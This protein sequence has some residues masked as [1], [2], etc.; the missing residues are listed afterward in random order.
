MMA[1]SL[2]PVPRRAARLDAWRRHLLV[3]CA[4]GATLAM[5]AHGDRAEAQAFNGS[6]FTQDGSVGYSRFSNPTPGSET[7]TI[8]SPSAIIQ[9]STTGPGPD[10]AVD[11]LPAGNIATFQNGE[12]V[13]NFVVLNRI[14]PDV[15][16]APVRFDGTVISRLFDIASGDLIGPGGTVIFQN[17][18]GIIVGANAVFDVGNLV[19]TS[20]GIDGD[21][22]G[23]G[24]GTFIN[25]G[26]GLD[27]AGADSPYDQAITIESGAQINALAEGSYVVLAAPRIEQGGAVR[28]NGNVA[29]VGGE[30]ATFTV[31]DGIFD[32]VLQAG[33]DGNETPIIHTGSTGGPASTG[34]GDQHNIYMLTAPYFFGQAT[35]MLLSGSIGY[36]DA[37]S[38]TFENGQIILSSGFAANLSGGKYAE[39]NIEITGGTLTSDVFATATRNVLAT[40]EDGALSFSGD[41]TAV[42][43]E[44]A[45]LGAVNGAVTVDGD[46]RLTALGPLD[47]EDGYGGQAGFAP[48][49]LDATGGTAEITAENGE[50]VTIVGNATLDA[51]A[52]GEFE[53]DGDLDAGEG[54]GGDVRVLATTG[55]SIA[56]GGDLEMTA[57]GEGAVTDYVP[58][59]GGAGRGGNATISA[60]NGGITVDGGLF[61]DVSGTGSRTTGSVTSQGA[62]GAG[63]FVGVSASNGSVEIAGAG[64]INASGTG[65]AV[66]LTDD[67][68]T[69]G[70]LG[71]GGFI[72]IDA[73]NGDVSLGSAMAI[74]ISG[75]GGAGPSGGQ[76]SGGSLFASA[77]GGEI[78]LGALG[79]DARG[80]GGASTEL[81]TGGAGFGGTV[82]A[83]AF[84]SP[85]SLITGTDTAINTDGIGGDGEVGGAGTAGGIS[86]VAEADEGSLQFGDIT[87]SSSGTGGAGAA[88]GG[89]G[90]GGDI[91]IGTEQGYGLGTSASVS[92]GGLDLAATGTGGDATGTTGGAGTGGSISLG[93]D[94]GQVTVTGAST[95]NVEGQ[96]GS[97][98]T[99]AGGT[100]TGG[101]SQ[102]FARGGATLSFTSL[103]MLS[104][105]RGG[106]GVTGGDGFGGQRVTPGG[107]LPGANIFAVDGTVTGDS[108]TLIVRGFG[109]DA[110]GAAGAGTGGEAQ[111]FS[112]NSAEP[113]SSVSIGTA[114]IEASGD[115]GASTGGAGGDALGGQVTVAAQTLNGAIAINSLNV[116]A[117]GQGGNGVTGGSAV[118]GLATV[119]TISGNETSGPVSGS[120]N[121]GLIVVTTSGRGG[122][123]TTGDG[124]D[125]TG[126]RSILLGRGST[127]QTGNVTLTSIGGGGA[128]ASGA[129]GDGAGGEAVIELSPRFQTGEP[130]D[131]SLGD[132]F[133]NAIGSAGTGAT[134]GAARRGLAQVRVLGGAADFASITMDVFGNDDPVNSALEGPTSIVVTDSQ[135]NVAG[136]VNVD[137]A[138]DADVSV[139][140]GSLAIGGNAVFSVAAAGTGNDFAMR[141]DN[142]TIAIDGA[143]Q[144]AAA[145]TGD[146]SAVDGV[147][148]TV[149]VQSL[150]GA[151]INIGGAT[152]ID[153]R[154]VGNFGGAGTGGTVRLLA[155]GGDLAMTGG[156][157]VDVDGLGSLGGAGTGGIAEIG[158][159]G[160]TAQ[161]GNID[162]SANGVGGD[163][164]SGAGGAGTGGVAVI[165]VRDD[166]DL[167]F[168]NA[169]LATDGIGGSGATG[170]AGTGG[171]QVNDPDVTPSGGAFVSSFGGTVTGTSL[172]MSS[173]GVGG[174]GTAGA[175]GDGQ[176]ASSTINVFNGPIPGL[177]EIGSATIDTS[178]TGGAG[179]TASG[180]DGAAGGN[181]AA[182]TL[183][184]A[185]AETL[186]GTLRVNSLTQIAAA[187]G[188]AGGAGT[189]GQGGRGGDAFG[190][191]VQAGGTSGLGSGAVNGVVE[192]G[193]VTG[194]VSAVGGAGGANGGAGGDGQGGSAALLSRGGILS[195]DSVTYVANGTGGAGNGGA[196]GAG[197]GGQAVA[198]LT[199]R[200]Q[201][202]IGSTNTI[203][204]FSATAG[205]TGGAGTTAGAGQYGNAYID[206]VGSTA[207]FGTIGLSAF[208]PDA[209]AQPGQMRVSVVDGQVDVTGTVNMDTPSFA[210]IT[211]TNGSVAVAGATT[212]TGQNGINVATFD[213]GAI[214]LA[215]A[216]LN[217]LGAATLVADTGSIDITGLTTVR[218][219]AFAAVATAGDIGFGSADIVVSGDGDAD[220]EASDGGSIAFSGPTTIEATDFEIA[221]ADATLT[222]GGDTTI[223]FE[224]LADGDDAAI[225]LSDGTLN[226][227]TSLTFNAGDMV[228]EADGASGIQGGALTVNASR[229]VAVSH[230][231]RGAA[232]TIDVASLNVQGQSF[233]A[234]AGTLTRA[235]GTIGINVADLATI[236]GTVVSPDI[237]IASRDIDIAAAGR[238]GDASTTQVTLSV[239]PQSAPTVIGGDEDEAGYTLTQ[240]EASRISTAS[241]QIAA[242]ASEGPADVVIRDLTLSATPNPAGIA[243]NRLQISVGAGE[244]VG[245][246]VQ[247]E[248][249]LRLANATATSGI[250][251][252]AGERIQIIN[253]A[254]SIR[255]LDSAGL[256]AGSIG[257][258]AANIWSA[259]QEIIDQLIENPNFEGR[260]DAL[261]ANDGDV[262]ER[263]YIEAGDV[264][265]RVGSTLFVQNSGTEE[266]FAGITV[267]QNTLT[268]QPTSGDVDVYAF[269]RRINADGTFVTN[270]EYFGEVDFGYGTS[271]YA[272]TA[273]FNQCVIAT[274]ACPGDPVTPEPPEIPIIEGPEVIEG[275]IEEVEDSVP[276][277]NPDRQEFVDV[278]FASE[279]LLEEPVTSGGDSGVWDGDDE[280]CVAGEG[281]TCERDGGG[282]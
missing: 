33:S 129:G 281:E 186:S 135:V 65:G 20:L 57:T 117:Q 181:A 174:A 172:V 99:G 233:D 42:A 220:L 204:A 93:A 43:Y 61:I 112:G 32:I 77:T 243:V 9:W 45:Q 137:T 214:S 35:T 280:Q 126:G 213:D 71:Q 282:Q 209:P 192:F 234:A 94:R 82:S 175:G 205:G 195:A 24:V 240:A 83:R 44:R 50:G 211:A 105:G 223:T 134:T 236:A 228:I 131:A 262:E 242:S 120:G 274:G 248:G 263:G 227:G 55:G 7:I 165:F 202:A 6:P 28:V 92:T 148:G 266:E 5:A 256:P 62:N 56:I 150:N 277:P 79:V 173:R 123:G 179:G 38:A 104:S 101:V 125:G 168:A 253:P 164:G 58:S 96:G 225:R 229:D 37:V 255:V 1:R 264:L 95:L 169:A 18:G 171:I 271:G 139:T 145:G 8:N 197:T 47:F 110:S 34:P 276:P 254:G 154:G 84:G 215:G 81:A 226:I 259:S 198:A 170:G 244:G 252:N 118:G 11:F 152:T 245:G 162:F 207:T 210:G 272:S 133:L 160:A 265:L 237:F 108:V 275:P 48:F 241:L 235:G 279:S 102:A 270:S 78:A 224:N 63:G 29:Y 178:A 27:F 53:F 128:S 217:S 155:Q 208:G 113:G 26:G 59:T 90:V 103:D 119:G 2:H 231:A 17:S 73:F 221:L 46:V 218:S 193:T 51:S 200:F 251:I 203:G 201:T 232:P 222:F 269:G 180:G 216:S 149:L 89:A 206:V 132:V 166:G 144:I 127:F 130:V 273:E 177:I 60:T 12:T 64:Q 190:G 182:G 278:S 185:G 68:G 140:N 268:I 158:A 199:T 124:G 122:D 260:N 153:A 72:S 261:L 239:N 219:A 100:G 14:F 250:D 161:I 13:S 142:G 75:T 167:T 116:R 258:Q 191:F 156:V 15:S 247:V 70:G 31:N 109:G 189:T 136:D 49:G 39:G 54:N 25:S 151:A 146:T 188:G 111:I 257:L 4:V 52:V 16:G 196:G 69:T 76:G 85:G 183:N 86:L 22:S 141:A 88:T 176:G 106:A 21:E 74:D 230:T 107:T 91:T 212:I 184:Y 66:E 143:L 114:F 194:Q 163:G 97:S 30:I 10:G 87:A 67:P 249:A 157:T 159:I 3:G 19:L 40:S 23:Y 138:T 238:L 187:T 147:G 80:R 115:G 98:G 41:F 267:T 246:V 36:D 121:Y